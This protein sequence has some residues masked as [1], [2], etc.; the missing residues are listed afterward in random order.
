VP[1]QAAGRVSSGLEFEART[2]DASL[3]SRQHLAHDVLLGIPGGE[4]GLRRNLAKADQ[5]AIRESRSKSHG[6]TSSPLNKPRM[7]GQ[8][9]WSGVHDAAAADDER[10]WA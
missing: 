5:Y 4:L 6:E 9:P 8:R 2:C 7:A 1:N 10:P 3:S